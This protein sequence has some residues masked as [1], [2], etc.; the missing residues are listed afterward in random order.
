VLAACNRFEDQV[1][2]RLYASHCF[3]YH[4]DALVSDD[5]PR[6][7]RPHLGPELDGTRLGQASYG[8]ARELDAHPGTFEQLLGVVLEDAGGRATDDPAPEQADPD[9]VHEV[10]LPTTPPSAHITAH[11]AIR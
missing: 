11:G 3:Y 2:R 8:H 10:N 5:L 7:R 1:A 4:L 9:S 6:V